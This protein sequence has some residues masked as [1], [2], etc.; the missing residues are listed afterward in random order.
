M[1][2]SVLLLY[3]LIPLSYM[4][5][6]IPFGL[7]IGR[8][9]G[10][11]PRQTGSRNIGATNV[12]RTMGRLPAL[13]TLIGDALKGALPVLACKIILSHLGGQE[14]INPIYNET[15]LWEGVVGLMAIV[16]HIYSVFL[17]FKGGKGVATGLGVIA[18][19]SPVSA[20]FVIIIWLIVVAVTRYSSLSAICA[21]LSLPFFILL[22]DR[23]A[24]KIYFGIILAFLVVLRHK[25]NIRRLIEGREPRFGHQDGKT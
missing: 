18:V 11:D 6:S 14:G 16:G 21:S 4:A 17:S 1:N 22:F 20:V 15:A 3:I 10:I 13:A 25:D 2:I 9:R 7:L 23:S 5:G 12:L 19:Y 8:M 24:F